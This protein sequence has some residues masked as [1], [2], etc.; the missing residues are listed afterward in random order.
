MQERRNRQFLTTGASG[1]LT[2]YDEIRAVKG[3]ELADKKQNARIYLE[4]ALK[5]AVIYVNG[6]RIQNSA[7]KFVLKSTRALKSS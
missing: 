3:R 7:K 4:E 5:N 2:K 6:D 1:N